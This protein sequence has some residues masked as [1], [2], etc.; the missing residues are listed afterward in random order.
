MSIFF[1]ETQ[2]CLK[3]AM[4]A[5][6]HTLKISENQRFPDVFMGLREAFMNF[7]V[8]APY[9][10]IISWGSILLYPG[11]RQMDY[12]D[13]WTKGSIFGNWFCVLLVHLFHESHN[14]C[15]LGRDDLKKVGKRGL[16]KVLCIITKNKVWNQV[17][18][19]FFEVFESDV[20]YITLMQY[21]LPL[22]IIA[23]KKNKLICLGAII[24]SLWEKELHCALNDCIDIFCFALRKNL[25]LWLQTSI[26]NRYTITKPGI[27]Y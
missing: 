17:F 9:V 6:P 14:I 23:L 18:L 21:I 15:K 13:I 12:H 22:K 20:Q 10:K 25:S 5:S 2:Q 26:N 16:E 4:K 7:W 1:D 19:T 27:F 11:W 3:N 24:L 8:A